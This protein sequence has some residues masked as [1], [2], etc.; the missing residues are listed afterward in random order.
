MVPHSPIHPGRAAVGAEVVKQVLPQ[1]LDGL[2]VER[3][4]DLDEH[5]VSTWSLCSSS[6]KDGVRPQE[7]SFQLILI[8]F[9]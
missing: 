3:N 6:S 7:R 1:L 2:Q 5:A 4:T 9:Q 8:V